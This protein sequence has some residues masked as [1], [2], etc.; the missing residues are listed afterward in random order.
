MDAPAPSSI[1]SVS[2]SRRPR[3][4]W[5]AASTCAVALVAVALF[6]AGFF[7]AS[8]S[9]E[10]LTT[11]LPVV[12][13][14]GTFESFV[15]ETGDVESSSNI[16]IRCE[17][18]SASSGGN[19]TILKIVEE[20][21]VVKKDDFLIQFDDALLKQNLTAQEIVV[22]TNDAGVIEARSELEKGKQV[23]TEYRDGTY[24]A[25]K[26]TLEGALL[27]AT[28]TQKAGRESLLYTER[29][30]RKGFV[31]RLQLAAEREA[32]QMAEKSVQIARI[33]L[34]VL[35]KFTHKRMLSE[36]QANIEKQKA[37]LT[38][39]QHKWKLSVQR[40]DDLQKEID[41]CLCLAPAAGQVVYANDYKRSSTVMIEEGAQIRQGQTVI[42]LPDRT[43][44]QVDTRISDSKLNLVAVG[45]E[46]EIVLDIDPDLKIRGKLVKVDPFPFPRRW[47]GEPIRYGATVRV[48]NP[49]PTLRSGQRAKVRI[50]VAEIPDVLQAPIQSV[51]EHEGKHFCLI[52]NGT[53]RWTPREVIVGAN[54][55]NFVVVEDGLESGDVVALNPAILWDDIIGDEEDSQKKDSSAPTPPDVAASGS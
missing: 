37:L 19:T 29:M 54:N 5:V 35:E 43:Q 39:A 26:E 4:R 38:A 27:Q 21:T 17:V 41:N 18:K 24:L 49:P 53:G 14:R 32:V 15:T 50:A 13:K 33:N 46:A 25:E 36:H 52:K 7:D 42:R 2:P 34:S 55:D 6:T 12:V 31:T 8:R 10:G 23:L 20:G 9:E 51:I 30:Y 22:A 45:H 1:P 40:R 3:L 47:H 44:M 48:L 11:L 28:S 16:E